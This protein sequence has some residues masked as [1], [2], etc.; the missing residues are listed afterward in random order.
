M[1]FLLLLTLWATLLFI[2]AWYVQH[3]YQHVLAAAAGRIVAPPGSEIELVDIEL[4]YPFD[5]SVFIALC[6]ASIWQ[7]ARRR[8]RAVAIGTPVMVILELIS[9]AL[10]M[11]AILSIM[12][13]P[14]ITIAAAEE[15]YR[16]A[17]GV[18]RV[19]GLIAAA[20]VWFYLLG[21][22]RLSL[23]ARTWLGG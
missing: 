5:V 9:V 21:R 6:L 12:S 19:T 13:N 2:P 20:G 8:L 16:F 7:P 15:V 11:G 4:F 22:E 18:I 23:M 1:K 14:R 10:A 3:P 17:T